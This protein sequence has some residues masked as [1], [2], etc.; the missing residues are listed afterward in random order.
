MK[1]IYESLDHYTQEEDLKG[2]N[3]YDAGYHGKQDAK[4]GV[5]FK[6]LPPVLFFQL[7]RFTFDF[8]KMQNVKVNSKY[9][10]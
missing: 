10:F 7:I 6:K 2:D 5:R 1:D 3:K 9:K 8:Q 4:K